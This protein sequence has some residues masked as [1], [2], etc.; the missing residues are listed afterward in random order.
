[1]V[2]D[3]PSFVLKAVEAVSNA[4]LGLVECSPPTNRMGDRMQI[5]FNG[6]EK[7]LYLI[8]TNEAVYRDVLQFAVENSKT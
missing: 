8:Q 7:E 3:I 5:R 4:G 1:M 6:V 2:S